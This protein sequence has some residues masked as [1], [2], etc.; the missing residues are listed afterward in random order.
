M[1]NLNK[2]LAM[3]VVFMMVLT[4]V[5]FAATFTDVAETSS[6]NTAIKVGTDLNLLKGYE[7]GTFQPEGEITR[8]EFA[9]IV[10]RLKGQE[11][12]AEGAKS[13]TNFTDVPAD[14]WASGYINIATQAGIINGYGDGKFG[15]ED[16]V[17]YQDAITMVVRALGYEPAIGSAGYPTGYLTQAGSLGLT[18]GVNGTNGVAINRG[19]VAQIAF[20]ALDVALMT[21]SGYGTFTQYVINDGYS[22]TNG[23]TNVKKTLL[24]ENHSIVKVQGIIKSSSD[25][26]SASTTATDKVY[27][28]VTNALY[29]KFGI[30][31]RNMEVGTSDA[32]NY[33]GKKCIIFIEYN[34]FEDVCT[35]KSLY[36]TATTDT[37]TVD[38]ADVEDYTPATNAASGELKYSSSSDRTT[39]VSIAEGAQVYYN[40]VSGAT[41]IPSATDLLDMNG[42]IELAL[43]DTQN[44]DADYDTVYITAYNTFVVDTI[45]KSASR[46]TS[47]ITD[48]ISRITYDESDGKVRA[49][50]VDANGAAMDWE[51]LNEYDVLIVKWAKTSAKDIYEAQIVENKVTGTVTSKSGSLDTKDFEV[52][53][54]GTSYEVANSAVESE[55]SIK[56]GD[57]GTYY[58]DN[59]NKVVYI[60]KTSSRSNNYAYVVNYGAPGAGDLV[61]TY[62]LKLVTKDNALV[63]YDLKK[64]IRLDDDSN[65]DVSGI[66]FDEMVGKVITYKTDSSDNITAIDTAVSGQDEDVFSYYKANT[67][68]DAYDKDEMS[69]KV[70]GKRI[71]INS[72]TIIFNVDQ[73]DAA[74]TEVVALPNLADDTAF[75]GVTIYDLDDDD[76]VGC[77]LLDDA[78]NEVLGANDYATFVTNVGETSDEDGDDVVYIKGYTSLDEVTYTTDSV[79]LTTAKSYIGKL[80]VPSYNADGSVKSFKVVGVDSGFG[81]D[82]SGVEGDLSYVNTKKNY[83]YLDGT[84][85]SEEDGDAYKIKPA[86]NVYV[87][88]STSTAR[89]KYKVG[90]VMSYI[91]YD[92][93]DGLYID[94][95]NKNLDVT[96]YIYINDGDVVDMVYYIN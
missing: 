35:I 92:D 48:G 82:R 61:D 75:Y 23:T 96:V 5:A 36:E 95:D 87:Y 9:A 59:N 94:S 21:Q 63:I 37:L 72:N 29:N 58:L 45:S 91:G 74:D 89:T 73:D 34:E 17:E 54:G 88:D 10:V 14:H 60:D 80:V 62:Q 15:P 66:D 1:K 12:Q 11:S 7:D 86:T 64:K 13:A 70:E 20:N 68:I 51:D 50:L 42:T 3:L 67:T 33:V 93:E 79:T 38:L 19:A 57:E 24:S 53:I 31:D 18:T 90:E 83:V 4:S 71:Y 6:Y 30:N 56:L 39:T 69:F 76:Y 22:S 25:T 26:D 2:V 81:T 28:D 55:A 46:V 49:S 27:V 40:G 43:L 85:G 8:A 52:T 77:L 84:L 16:L 32:L 44:T 78:R 47:K 41:N 65:V